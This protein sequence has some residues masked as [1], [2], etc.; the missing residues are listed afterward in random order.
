[1]RGN[2]I[3]TYRQRLRVVLPGDDA[4]LIEVREGQPCVAE[5]IRS[6]IFGAVAGDD[7]VVFVVFSYQAPI[8]EGD[9]LHLAVEVFNVSRVEADAVGAGFIRRSCSVGGFGPLSS[10]SVVQVVQ[11]A[12]C[13]RR[14]S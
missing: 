1:M 5:M 8:R 11:H 9:V 4:I 10:S 14:S 12:L 13:I 6:E 7:D 3:F 2:F